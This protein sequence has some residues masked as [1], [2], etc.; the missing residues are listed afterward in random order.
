MTRAQRRA[1]W[2][3]GTALAVVAVAVTP[4]GAIVA[5]GVA[6]V[7]DAI[8][9]RGRR[10]FLEQVGAEV[11]RELEELRPDLSPDDRARV[12]AIVAAQAG[13][14]TSD[15]RTVAW[16]EGWNFGN[17]TAGSS[18]HGPVVEGGDTE[19]DAAGVYVPIV[20]R[21]RKYGSIREAVGD[22]FR[23]LSW[24]RYVAARDALMRG[25][26]DGY[27]AALRAGG[28]FTAPLEDYR[29]GIAARLP[30]ALEALA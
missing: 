15:G 10:P 22:F 7:V 17:V 20:Q 27:A 13:L 24:T 12:A 9:A 8:K 6:K 14:E 30:T 1:L 5:A 29:G 18:W 23:L 16:R 2:I 26:A 11:R 19:P 28:Y 21:F 4:G 3:A 25:D